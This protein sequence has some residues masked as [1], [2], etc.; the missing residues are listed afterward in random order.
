[1]RIY[2]FTVLLFAVLVM[3]KKKPKMPRKPYDPCA[4]LGP[5]T[6]VHHSKYQDNM[7]R[8]QEARDLYNKC[9]QY[10]DLPMIGIAETPY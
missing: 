7:K 10:H 5:T 6:F 4:H 1:M 8:Y 2:M 9:R 3:A